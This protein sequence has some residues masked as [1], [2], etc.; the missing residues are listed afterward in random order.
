MTSDVEQFW[1]NLEGELQ[2]PVRVRSLGRCTEGPVI[3]PRGREL[4]GVFF[5]TDTANFRN[6]HYH[7]PTDTIETLHPELYAAA[8][9]L[10]AA[11]ATY[12]A[13]AIP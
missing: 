12:W 5:L 2:E 11:A 13:G 1:R 3:L 9:G 7:E 6:P 10:T 8:V 4:W